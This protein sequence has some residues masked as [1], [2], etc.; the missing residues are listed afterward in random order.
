MNAPAPSPSIDTDKLEIS[1]SSASELCRLGLGTMI[2]I[3]QGFELEMKGAIPDTVPVQAACLVPP[4]N[5]AAL[6]DVLDR[7]IGDSKAR[8]ALLKGARDAAGQIPGWQDAAQKF[9]GVLLLRT[10]D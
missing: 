1:L 2:D 9:A 6:T 8:S 3:R 5:V 10:Q 4:G 7:L